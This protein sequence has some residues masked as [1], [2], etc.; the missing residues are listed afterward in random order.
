MLE[1]R[2]SGEQQQITTGKENVMDNQKMYECGICYFQGLARDFTPIT[3]SAN[4]SALECPRCLN[5]DAESFTEHSV[6]AEWAA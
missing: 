2:L 4:F 3:V 5:N 1:H 6:S